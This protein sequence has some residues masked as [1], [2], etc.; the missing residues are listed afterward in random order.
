MANIISIGTAVPAHQHPQQDI[1]Q[2]MQQAFGLDETD[3]R[4]LSFLYSHSG[5]NQRYSVLEEYNGKQAATPLMSLKE[6]VAP[7]LAAR[8]ELFSKHALSLSLEAVNDCIRGHLDAH[9]ITHL[10]T[11][12]CTGMSAPGLDIELVNALGLRPDCFRTSVNFMGCYAAIHALKLAQMICASTA[13]ANV[14]VVATELCT[15]HFQN[16]YNVDN[17]AS[18]LLFSD[19]SAA[20]LVS[21]TIK[22]KHTLSLT[23][24]YSYIAN[25]G[26]NDMSWK[27]SEK[28]FLMTLSSYIPALIKDDIGGL[29]EKALLQAQVNKEDI[30]HWCFHPGGRKIL[31]VIQQQT[32]LTDCAMSYSADVLCNYGNMSSPTILFVL[33]KILENIGEK[34]ASVFGVAFG[35]GLTMETFIASTS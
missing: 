27:I 20:V 23:S 16:E 32:G 11:V 29:I 31:D 22:K 25:K 34:P 13:G 26:Y 21:N 18:S 6:N 7:S 19:G 2:F 12:S 1:L 33:K 28:G 14:M 8:M 17:A 35:P 5:I 4:K 15:I 9:E 30:T 10:I 24:F 3:K